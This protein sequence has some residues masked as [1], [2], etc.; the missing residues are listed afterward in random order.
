M[1][2]WQPPVHNASSRLQARAEELQQEVD[3]Q[4]LTLCH[5]LHLSVNQFN[6]PASCMVEVL[7]FF[8]EET[9][10]EI[11]GRKK[12]PIRAD[13]LY[14]PCGVSS[15]SRFG[16]VI[17]HKQRLMENRRSYCSESDEICCGFAAMTFKR[18]LLT[19]TALQ[20][21]LPCQ[22]LAKSPQRRGGAECHPCFHKLYFSHFRWL[23]SVSL[24]PNC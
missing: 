12:T 8:P 23:C 21:E 2:I 11:S 10:K 7:F 22:I 13:P 15:K 6:L 17:S 14:H 24:L 5:V 1:A 16:S 4:T 3:S 19:L 18:G 20:D 9:K